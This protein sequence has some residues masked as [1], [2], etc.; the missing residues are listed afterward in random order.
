MLSAHRDE[1]GEPS[2]N[3]RSAL[4]SVCPVFDVTRRICLAEAQGQLILACERVVRIIYPK[5]FKGVIPMVP[6]T[7]HT[8]TA[9]W[10]RR[11]LASLAGAVS[12]A[13]L[14]LLGGAPAA[15][16]SGS[17]PCSPMGCMND[18]VNSWVSGAGGGTVMQESIQ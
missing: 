4:L 10:M 16:A 14:A 9:P 7:T 8:T 5:V 6:E 2:V 13:G 11:R 15:N 1:F 17:G 3:M 18:I 12:I